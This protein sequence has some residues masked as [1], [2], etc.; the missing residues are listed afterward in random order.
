MSKHQKTE[1]LH[2][3]DTLRAIMMM[4]GIVLHSA[5]TYV[6]GDPSFGWPMRD[7]NADSG[8]LGWLLG[9]IHNFRMPI[10]MLIA[11]FFAALLFYERSPSRM[12]RNRFHRLVLPMLVFVVLLWPLV[13]LGFSWS[14]AIFGWDETFDSVMEHMF[15]GITLESFREFDTWI[16]QTTMHLWFLYYLIMFSATSFALGMLFRRLPGVRAFIGE[17]MKIILCSPVKKLVVFVS[18]NFLILYLMDRNWVST[19]TAWEP[20]LGTF[21]FYFYFY[22]AGWL[23]FKAKDHLETFMDHDW[24]YAISAVA[25]FTAYWNIE[26]IYLTTEVAALIKSITVWLFVFGFMGLFMRYFSRGSAKMRYVSDS[27]YWVYLLHLPLTAFLPGMIAGWAVPGFI[28]FVVVV[29]GTTAVC[30]VTYHYFVRTTFIGQFL[31]G[32]KYPRHAVAPALASAAKAT[33]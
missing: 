16:P 26:S 21:V 28:K 6:G 17:Q 13:V 31:N 32:R 4:L 9:I 2:S 24:L 29:S 1:R 11:G 30:M 3:L 10:F 12:I 27:A 18:I 23:I 14:N 7:P 5:I 20:H 25:L 22:M 19:S 15:V 33:S 8:F